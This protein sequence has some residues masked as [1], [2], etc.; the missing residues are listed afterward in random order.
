MQTSKPPS[1]TDFATRVNK[2]I[3][4][5]QA[6]ILPSVRYINILVA[7]FA[8]LSL[9]Y[10]FVTASDRSIDLQAFHD[11]ANAWVSGTYRIGEGPMYE[12]PPYSVVL[13]SPLAFLSFQHLVF[14]WL[15]LN[16]AATTWIYYAAIQLWGENWS[17]RPR[18]YFLALL[19]IGAPFRVTLRNGQ[20]SL[21]ICALLLG[22][23]LARKWGKAYLA[24]CLLGLALCK[25]SL[26]L[27]FVLYFAWKK[28]WKI[29]APACLLP[30]L[31]TE[32]FALRFGVSIFTVILTYLKTLGKIADTRFATDTGT[33]EIQMLFV[34]LTHG[35]RLWTTICSISLCLVALVVMAFVF[36][37]SRADEHAHFAI[38][39]LFSLWAVYHR[40]YDEVLCS[41][42]A[43]L[44][45]VFLVQGK[46]LLFSLIS[47]SGLLLLALSIP[48]VLIERLGI[49]AE[50]LS[51]N[52]LGFIGVH[53][54]RII[55]FGLFCGLL[56]LLA[57]RHPE[58][59]G[60]MT[61]IR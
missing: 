23:L 38:L 3:C 7:L 41:I 54:E 1:Q 4:R 30:V 11:G 6:S 43:A 32:I 57:T 10:A 12:Y 29:V 5:L 58:R 50:T 15:L 61:E 31:L 35:N 17:A 16:L 24:G 25:Y 44:L 36:K 45:M 53:I 49:D 59:E 51:H 21:I 39:S 40:N 56:Y 46:H 52:P 8:A 37:R 14:L 2:T 20:L 22:V 60:L 13:L 42:S 18:Y 33:T 48:G 27:P 26:S 9:I 28:E 47:S 55:V 34:S 19:V